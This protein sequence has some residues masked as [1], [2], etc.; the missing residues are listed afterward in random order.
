MPELDARAGVS[1]ASEAWR[2]IGDLF[3][4]QKHR[5][6]AIASEFE[7]SPPQLWALRALEP[8]EPSPMSC[9]AQSLKCDAS[10]VTGIVDRLQHRGLV[11]RRAAEHDR[12]VKHLLLT[13][14]GVELRQR[15]I[16]RL[17]APPAGIAALSPDE[18][19]Q[20]RDLLRRALEH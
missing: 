17:D 14:E 11:E 19:A 10:N 5:F 13:D 7:L 9:L 2:L 18:Q 3:H 15:L 20:L 12:R 8:D 6:A 1:P 16:E 4:G